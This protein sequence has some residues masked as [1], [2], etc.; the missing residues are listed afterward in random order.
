MS[1]SGL[2]AAQ[3]R[4]RRLQGA[5]TNYRKVKRATGCPNG[6]AARKIVAGPREAEQAPGDPGRREGSPYE[7]RE[8]GTSQRRPKRAPGDP[9][10]QETQIRYGKP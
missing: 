3:E 9:D 2:P 5:A 4:L 10:E 6:Q 8:C 7:H 1:N